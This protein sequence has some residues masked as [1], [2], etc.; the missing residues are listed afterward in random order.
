MDVRLIFESKNS[1]FKMFR[2]SK[3]QVASAGYCDSISLCMYGAFD[4]SIASN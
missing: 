4:A 1:V 2:V 3:Q